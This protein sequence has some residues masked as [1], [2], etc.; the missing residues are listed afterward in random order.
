MIQYVKDYV[1]DKI[2]DWLVNKFLN[3]I[4]ASKLVRTLVTI[5]LIS[6][7]NIILTKYGLSNL[8][9]YVFL[10]SFI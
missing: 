5:D 6:I 9:S 10:L 3:Q 1:T 4:K 8:T 7:V 2:Q